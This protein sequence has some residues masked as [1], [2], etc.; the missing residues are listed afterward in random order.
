MEN[1]ILPSNNFGYRCTLE[2]TEIPADFLDGGV[3]ALCVFK[4]NRRSEGEDSVDEAENTL[5]YGAV[6]G[7]RRQ[8]RG[9]EWEGVRAWLTETGIYPPP[10]GAGGGGGGRPAPSQEGSGYPS[11]GGG[12]RGTRK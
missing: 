4:S 2:V 9:V 7:W 3:V 5:R 6:C 1:M 8:W 12:S 10:K 11:G